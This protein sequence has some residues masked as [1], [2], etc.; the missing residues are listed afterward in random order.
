[1]E[2]VFRIRA[3][4]DAVEDVGGCAAIVQYREFG[5]VEEATRPFKGERDKVA[6]L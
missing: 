4:I 3:V 1:M 6:Q 5:R 2:C